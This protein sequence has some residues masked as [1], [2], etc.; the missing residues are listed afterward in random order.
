M[1]T[2]FL[3]ILGNCCG[4]YSIK[5]IN[6]Y[7]VLPLS[8]FFTL[9][10]VFSNLS[11]MTNTVGT[12]QLLKCLSDPCILLFERYI[13]KTTYSTKVQ[14]SFLPMV[15]GVFINSFYDIDKLPLMVS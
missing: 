5:P 1:A 10:I 14:L 3:S 8:I 13:F 6:I 7:K 11:L 2:T 9:F 12:Y 15:L 4:L